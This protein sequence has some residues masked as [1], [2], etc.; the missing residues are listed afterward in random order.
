MLRYLYN[1]M[2][3]EESAHFLFFIENNPAM[4]EQY[5]EMKE[6]FDVLNNIKF[7]PAR[8]SMDHIMSYAS[9]D[10]FSMQ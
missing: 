3:S 4:M 1:E 9:L 2:S 10:G 5:A 6:G 7:S 8:S